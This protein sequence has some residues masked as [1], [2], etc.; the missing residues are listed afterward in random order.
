MELLLILNHRN[1]RL[2][3]WRSHHFQLLELIDLWE[4]KRPF[5]LSNHIQ[6]V[7]NPLFIYN[8]FA[9]LSEFKEPLQF[10]PLLLNSGFHHFLSLLLLL[11]LLS[12]TLL[13]V[14]RLTPLTVISLSFSS[15][16]LF[17]PLSLNL[18]FPNLHLFPFSK[19]QV[20]ALLHWLIILSRHHLSQCFQIIVIRVQNYNIPFFLIFRLPFAFELTSLFLLCFL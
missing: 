2:I 10:L 19:S 1:E 13:G 6:Q 15:R 3:V 4:W 20:C 14:I 11:K 16:W 18:F 7:I 17:G 5:S 9:L 12:H 8:T